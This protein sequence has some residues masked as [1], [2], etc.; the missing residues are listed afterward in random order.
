M[1]SC[2]GIFA[3]ARLGPQIRFYRKRLKPRFNHI[4]QVNSLQNERLQSKELRLQADS[5]ES[6]ER[7]L[8]K[9]GFREIDESGPVDDMLVNYLESSK[10][11]FKKS[12]QHLNSL[13]NTLGSNKN[14][15]QNRMR[16]LFDF[17][18]KESEQE[19]RRL[20]SMGPEQLLMLQ[21]I[22]DSEKSNDSAEEISSERELEKA[23]LRELMESSQLEEDRSLLPNTECLFRVLSDLNMNR[24]A[25]EDIISLEQMVGAFEVSKLLPAYKLRQRGILLSGHLIYSLG[26]VRM[27]PVNESFYI[28]SLVYYGFYKKALELFNTYRQKVE[29]RWWFE[30]GMMVSLR[31]NHIRQFD[32]LLEN[33]LK[34]FGNNYVSPKVLRTAIRKKLYL[35]D[36][37][38]S[39]RLTNLLVSVASTY[40]LKSSASQQQHNLHGIIFQNESQAD[41]FLNEK[42]QV[43]EA[44]FVAIIQYHFFRKREDSALALLAEFVKLP[45][46]NKSILST[47]LV[48]LKLHLLR[49]FEVLE[50]DMHSL[51]SG[52]DMKLLRQAFHSATR[53]FPVDTLQ[54]KFGTVLFDSVSDIASQPILTQNLEQYVA[55]NL[56]SLPRNPE[57]SQEENAQSKKLHSLLKELLKIG[58]EDQAAL[59]MKET[60][61]VTSNFQEPSPSLNEDDLPGINAHHYA[62]WIDHYSKK[63]QKAKNLREKNHY[64]T[65]IKEI[66]EKVNK[67]DIQYNSVLLTSLLT[68]FRITAN[69]DNCFNIINPLME[70]RCSK[71]GDFKESDSKLLSFFERR[72]I[73][74]SLYLQ[75]WRTLMLYF[76]RFENGLG[77][78]EIRSNQ[79]AWKYKISAERSKISVHPNYDFRTLFRLMVL[80]D[81]VLPDRPFYHTIIQAFI[82]TRDW[83]YIPAVL[84]YMRCVNGIEIDRKLQRYI[85]GGLKLE[86]IAVERERIESQK[87]DG[88]QIQKFTTPIVNTARR[89]VENR[90]KNGDILGEVGTDYNLKV[91]QNVLEF[92]RDHRSHEMDRVQQAFK[93]VGIEGHQ[94]MI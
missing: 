59:L 49:S 87:A 7:D 71:T 35:R 23:I 34:T 50:K 54:K 3:R 90:I 32:R 1:I 93:E 19:V 70:F 47:A 18:L 57:N 24:L 17:L 41:D 80:E 31:A 9:L 52:K 16:A 61:P 82:R 13:K 69:L 83:A 12:S 89:N 10:S 56:E 28:E 42:E 64:E 74:K 33:S 84:R 40:G 85:N 63:A 62:L 37:Q 78:T 6:V 30:M 88:S 21:E 79:K 65:K 26:T 48:N 46:V 2:R 29:K 25:K 67:N 55:S 77:I 91:E 51:L 60:S 75:I 45:D 27:D 8:R 76:S 92:L 11:P 39:E 66:V 72:E 4:P 81:N 58:K 43:T 68:H 86:Y 94:K 44:D 5:P 36:Y 73:T 38:S 53:R 22:H 15:N 20:E 14:P